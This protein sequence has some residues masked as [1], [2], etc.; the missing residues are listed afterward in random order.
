[1]AKRAS[2]RFSAAEFSRAR[3]L[4]VFGDGE[5]TRDYV[6]VSD[7]ADATYRAATTKLDPP[8]QVDDRSFNV[9]TGEGKSVL[10]LAHT[11]LAAA[12]ARAALEFAPKRAGRAGPLVHRA[13][14]GRALVSVGRR[15]FRSLKD[16]PTRTRGSPRARTSPP[17]KRREPEPRHR[18]LS[19]SFRCRPPRAPFRRAR[20]TWC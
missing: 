13:R 17:C 6:H 5:Q 16:L 2:S 15:G 20:S 18:A 19:F 7:V 11:L 12:G 1:M 9:G 10:E 4:T 8:R 3:P 14:Q